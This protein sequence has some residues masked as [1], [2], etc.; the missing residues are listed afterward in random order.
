MSSISKQDVS[1]IDAFVSSVTSLYER[2]VSSKSYEPSDELMV[3]YEEISKI[4]LIPVSPVI[5]EQVCDFIHVVR[6]FL[7]I[8]IRFDQ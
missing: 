8:W 4:V 3:L 7:L 1:D 5:E 2:L 6:S